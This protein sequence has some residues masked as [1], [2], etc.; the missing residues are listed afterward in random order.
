[1]M[2]FWY[3]LENAVALT[4]YIGYF[5]PVAGVVEQVQADA[6]EARADDP[7]WADALEVI[8]ETAVPS[9]EALANVHNYKRL[10]EAE[11][12]EWNNLF[13]EVVAG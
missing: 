6:E 12:A 4:E 2:N 1:M 9:E 3:D 10:D 13:N 8:A 5:S 7:E 11:E